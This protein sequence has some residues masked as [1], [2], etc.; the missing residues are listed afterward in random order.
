MKIFLRNK[1]FIF[2]IKI[3]YNNSL[4]ND[5]IINRDFSSSPFRY[6]V[7]NDLTKVFYI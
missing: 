7:I 1:L 5:Y 6:I 3:S 4:V 2:V